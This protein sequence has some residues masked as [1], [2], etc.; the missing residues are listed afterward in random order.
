MLLGHFLPKVCFLLFFSAYLDFIDACYPEL[1][2]SSKPSYTAVEGY[3]RQLKVFVPFFA[4]VH[5][6]VYSHLVEVLKKDAASF[7]CY[8]APSR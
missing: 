2:A 4:T 3:D 8:F 7:Q 1:D 6:A 5:N